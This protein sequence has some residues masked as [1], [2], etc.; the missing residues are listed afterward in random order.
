MDLCFYCRVC[1]VGIE[2]TVIGI[3]CEN[4]KVCIR[5][6]CD[7]YRSSCSEEEV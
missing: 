6:A 5:Y 4:H 1:Q 2:S 3:D 7:V